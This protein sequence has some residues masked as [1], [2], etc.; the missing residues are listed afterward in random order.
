M[1]N[2]PGQEVMNP[3]AYSKT[4]PKHP[5][6]ASHGQQPRSAYPNKAHHKAHVQAQPQYY[7]PS[8]KPQN[9]NH[10]SNPQNG[11]HHNP[12]AQRRPNPMTKTDKVNKQIN[13]HPHQ[14]HAQPSRQPQQPQAVM[15]PYYKA[16]HLAK[17]AKTKPIP[18]ASHKPEHFQIS[19]KMSIKDFE[20]LKL[21][22]KGSFGQVWQVQYKQTRQIYALKVL[23]KKDLVARKQVTHTNTE[24]RI[25]ANIDHPFLVSLRFAFQTKS[26]L[27]MVMDFFN[28][29]ELFW[30]LQ[31]ESKFTEK[32]ARFYSA[33]ICLAIECLHS[34]DITYRD[35]KPENILLDHDG[36]IKITDFGLSKESI[37]SDPNCIT[38]T[39]CGSPEYLAPEMLLQNGYNQMVDWWS[40]GTILYEMICGL[41]PFYDQNIQKMYANILHAPIPF[42]HFMSK[43]SIELISKLLHKNPLKRIKCK[44]LK[45]SAFFECI[46]W[47]KL[48]KKEIEPPFKP[49]VLSKRDSSFF[50]QFPNNGK[51]YLNAT[52]SFKTHSLIAAEG[53]FPNFTY[54][55]TND[56]NDILYVD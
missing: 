52:P 45:R 28:G 6:A 41:P 7:K 53:Q 51:T 29:G 21:V 48:Y 49:Q 12:P 35:L 34:H 2:E 15:S 18:R 55:E 36:H 17:Q 54:D 16:N 46:D 22:G 31:N 11:H 26:K 39:F 4:Q 8:A 27:Y 40:F 47:R 19:T 9:R 1:G 43:P 44:E 37:S 10:N 32:R 30:H 14:H 50:Q 25:L 3:Q 38:R 5:N 56:K 42:Y 23:K 33:E 20:M 13:G 24:R